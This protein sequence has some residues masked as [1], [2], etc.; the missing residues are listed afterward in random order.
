MVRHA[1]TE[2]YAICQ[3]LFYLGNNRSILH[4]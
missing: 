4:V 1:D 3:P 2:I